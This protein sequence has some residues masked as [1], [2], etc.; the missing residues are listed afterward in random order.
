MGMTVTEENDK[1]T[2]H[3]DAPEASEKPEKFGRRSM[4]AMNMDAAKAR[5]LVARI[6]WGLCVLFAGVL[7]AAVLLIAIDA[8]S[9]NE[10]VRFIINFADNVDL[11]YFDLT[12]PIKDFD[13]SV[14]DPAE[15]VKTALFNY[16]IAAIVWLVVGRLLDR[17]IRP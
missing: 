12:D 4:P 15:D 3:S 6:I 11:G 2:E 14:T 13:K 8:N 16:G 9:R 17:V 5:T 7:A 10:L 1:T